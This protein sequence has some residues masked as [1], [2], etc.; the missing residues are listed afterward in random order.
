MVGWM[1]EIRVRAQGKVPVAGG[2][3]TRPAKVSFD[4]L[5]FMPAQLN[6][7]A[8]DYFREK[9]NTETIIG[10][11]SKHPLKLKMPILLGAMSFGALSESAKIALAKASSI[12]GTAANTG[13][14][15]ML[16]SER[17]AA[18]KLIVQ[19]STGRFGVDDDYLKAGDAVEFKIGQGAKPGQGGLLPGDKV[20]EKIAKLRRVPAGMPVHSP[21][22]HL[23]IH[24][25]KELKERIDWIRDVT[26]GKPVI[27]KIAAGNV[28]ADVKQAIKAEPDA[29]AIDGM[30]AGTGAA[31]LVMM[32]NFGI[33]IISAIA[34]ARKTM[35]RLKADQELLA[36]GGF[37]S[38]S[39]IA[40]ILALGADAVFMATAPLVAMGCIQCGLCYQGKCPVGITTQDPA[41]EKKLDPMA[42][43]RAANFLN[44]CNEEVKMTAGAAGKS[45]VHDLCRKDLKSLSLIM[46]KT[47]G[48]PII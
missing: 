37:N 16:L 28:E 29:L 38:G 14:G 33:P 3:S 47:T 34:K 25:I 18:D 27:L 9:I 2:R 45:N 7:D 48:I 10:K 4:D 36:G 8:V 15:G 30:H 21:P 43:E 41:F 46:E 26:K 1:N 40:K 17:K 22:R 5:T 20:T 19:Y 32:D 35:D 44:M 12:T 39:D 31:P 13:E 6:A 11:A 24:N 23:D 42:A